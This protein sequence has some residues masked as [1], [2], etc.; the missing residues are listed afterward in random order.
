[1]KKLLISFSVSII[2]VVIACQSAKQSID[3]SML[4]PGDEIH[5]MTLSTGAAKAPPLAAFCSAAQ[6]DQYITKTDCHIPSKLSEV[7]IGHVFNIIDIPTKL[8][9]S[10]FTWKLTVDEKPVDLARFGTY[11]FAMPTLSTRPSPVREI[12][13]IFTAWDVVLSNL[14]PGVHTMQGL[15][16][17]ET[18]T[19]TW[20]VNLTIEASD[21]ADSG[22]IP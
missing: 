17:S 19:Y 12:F 5:G 10:E 4:R 2:A 7:A 22:P 14:K 8:D 11:D 9:W 1:M 3:N 15:A 20:F 6:E 13:K 18:D 21:T 16:Q